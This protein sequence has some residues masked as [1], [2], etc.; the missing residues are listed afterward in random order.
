MKKWLGHV[1]AVGGIV[2]FAVVIV[3]EINSNAIS[4]WV[5]KTDDVKGDQRS[6]SEAF[7]AS[8]QGLMEM[9]MDDFRRNPLLGMGFQVAEYTK[10]YAAS[11]KGLMLSSPIEKGVI[12]VMV[13]GE[14]GVVGA[15]VFGVFLLVFYNGCANRKLY[16]T[17]TMM[18]VFLAI[19]LGEATFFS[20]GGAGGI[21]WLF[22]IVGGYTL[23]LTLAAINR[24]RY[25]SFIP[26]G[27]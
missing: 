9:C 2:L 22:C 8:R 15:I 1:L 3:A 27:L 6:I 17:S 26:Y 13:L 20:P 4:R 14:T 21:E 24:Q 10:N 5:R 18:T 23:D 19:N 25:M 7:T 12:P 11:S 16:L